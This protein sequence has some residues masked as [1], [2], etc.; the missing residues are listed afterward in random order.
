MKKSDLKVGDR[1]KVNFNKATANAK[2]KV[3]IDNLEQKIKDTKKLG[4]GYF[5]V[6]Q[7]TDYGTIWLVAEDLDIGEIAVEREALRKSR[8]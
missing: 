6:D 1:V 7:I 5:V 2:N 4:T 8:K 3:F